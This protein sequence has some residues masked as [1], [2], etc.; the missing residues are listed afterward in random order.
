MDLRCRLAALV[1]AALGC[2]SD[3]PPEV[4]STDTSSSDA[5]GSASATAVGTTDTEGTSA[6]TTATTA[7][8]D[9]LSPTAACD[10]YLACAAAT[11]PSELGPLL[12]TYGPD[13]TCWQSTQ[14]VAD[15]CDMAC[16]VGLMQLQDGFPDEPA[17]G[18]TTTS[19]G[20]TSGGGSTCAETADD[21]G[22]GQQPDAGMY[23]ACDNA[24][25]CV[26]LDACEAGFCTTACTNAAVDC[27]P[28]PGGT[29]VSG[30]SICS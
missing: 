19:T 6:G 11:I 21:T 17:C 27:D 5:T 24:T 18:G 9:G 25:D 15:Q 20:D 12:E 30:G 14:E 1:V 26:G 13:G 10:A 3:S 8:T 2:G 23:S 7:S 16:E 28:S 22:T 29:P 4:A